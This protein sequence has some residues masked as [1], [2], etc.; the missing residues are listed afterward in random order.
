MKS[1]LSATMRS[2]T[3]KSAI[4]NARNQDEALGSASTRATATK[5]VCIA[6][7]RIRQD[8]GVLIMRLLY[9]RRSARRTWISSGIR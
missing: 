6:P 7:P 2:G 9:R 8:I 3:A 4:V 5:L 1:A